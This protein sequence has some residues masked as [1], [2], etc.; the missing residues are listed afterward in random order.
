MADKSYA[1]FASSSD[2]FSYGDEI[3]T[4][5]IVQETQFI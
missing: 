2:W 1:R 5:E 3:Q 4:V